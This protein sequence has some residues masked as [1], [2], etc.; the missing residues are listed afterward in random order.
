MQENVIIQILFFFYKGIVFS[1]RPVDVGERVCIRLTE[2]S[3]RWS[4]VLRLGFSSHDPSTIQT[5]PKY[6]CPDLTGKP[7]FWAKAL[8]EKYAESNALIHYYFT[9]NGDVHYGV[10]GIDKG[11][12]FSG[13]DARQ[14]LWCMIDLYGN[15]TAI[16]MV[17]MR[18]SLNNFGIR[19]MDRELENTSDESHADTPDNE[20]DNTDTVENVSNALN[21]LTV[22]DDDD[23]LDIDNDVV[24]AQLRY[25][26]SVNFTPM[27]FHH[28][29][30]V[31]VVLNASRT[32]AWR[33]EDEYSN[34]YIFTSQPIRLG[35]RMVVQ[36]VETEN[37]YIGSL[38]FGVTSCDPS[39]IDVS[40]LPEDGDMLLDRY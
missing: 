32:L 7:G 17:D 5:L 28:T 22:G 2:L 29:T 21:N 18:R 30:G 40:S 11:L 15:C 16:E 13:V 39:N 37:M 34:G 10:N 27:T 19:E 24:I 31:N 12:F 8:A 20:T 6:A 38:A 36:I 33:Q 4:G 23:G 25:Y 14:P 26:G 35:E 1:D 9:A 3:I